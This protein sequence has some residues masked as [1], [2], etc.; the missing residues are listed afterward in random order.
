VL[1][2]LNSLLPR[3]TRRPAPWSS[4]RSRRSALNT[5]YYVPAAAAERGATE[6]VAP[7]PAADAE[8]EQ[9]RWTPPR[10][11]R[12]LVVSREAMREVRG[13]GG[14]SSPGGPSTPVVTG[15][16][17]AGSGLGGEPAKLSWALDPAL[18]A[19]CCA[20]SVAAV[21]Y[22]KRGTRARALC[23]TRWQDPCERDLQQDP[24]RSTLLRT[25]WASASAAKRTVA[26]SET[27]RPRHRLFQRWLTV[28][29]Q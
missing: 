9:A 1:D 4:S 18:R 6:A 10:L 17:A 23:G 21:V 15:S 11:P 28:P 16:Q 22:R 3:L 2:R 24:S 20:R 5:L 25:Y 7:P 12:L 29:V 14:A 27:R 19:S 13:K 8:M 26:H